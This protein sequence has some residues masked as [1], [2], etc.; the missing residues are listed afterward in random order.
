VENI[1]IVV[2]VLVWLGCSATFVSVALTKQVTFIDWDKPAKW[3][4]LVLFGLLVASSGVL[5]QGISERDF[6]LFFFGGF[7]VA[8][9]LSAIWYH[10]K[11]CRQRRQEESQACC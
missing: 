4:G 9:S 6:W 8:E 5:G 3:K 2:A 11:W 1:P 10:I 7:A